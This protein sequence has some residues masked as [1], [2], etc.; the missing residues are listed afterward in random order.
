MK[1]GEKKQVETRCASQTG[2]QSMKAEM[3]HIE[4]LKM[5]T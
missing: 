2:P 5:S 1:E 4:T 3:M